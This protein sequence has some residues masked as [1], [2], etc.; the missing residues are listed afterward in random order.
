MSNKNKIE[1]LKVGDKVVATGNGDYYKV[2]DKGVVIELDLGSVGDIYSGIRVRFNYFD[3]DNDQ[4]T[5]KGT[6]KRIKKSKFNVG[7]EVIVKNINNNTTKNIEKAY[8]TVSSSMEKLI[9]KKMI[10]NKS[11]FEECYTLSSD[12]KEDNELA[13]QY[14]I[15]GRYIFHKSWLKHAKSKSERI[16]DLEVRVE[17]LDSDVV[18]AQLEPEPKQ[19]NPKGGGFWV[20][21]NGEAEETASTIGSCNFGTEFKTEEQATKGAEAFRKYHRLYQLALELN[22]GWEP[23]WSDGDQAKYYIYYNNRSKNHR[24]GSV[25]LSDDISYVYFKSYGTAGAAIEIIDNGGL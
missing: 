12:N 4:H 13:R 2:G 14:N 23:D 22:E 19:W 21:H 5:H 15:D 20:D 10:I 16:S 8:I 25:F 17:A 6:L 11:S 3:E 24:V 9:G 1:G 18:S 7:D